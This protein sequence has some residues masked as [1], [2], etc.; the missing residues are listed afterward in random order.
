[1]GLSIFLI[2][3]YTAKWILFVSVKRI[4]SNSAVTELIIQK[5]FEYILFSI[6]TLSSHWVKKIIIKE[7]FPKVLNK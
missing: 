5:L 6:I 1:M 2:K 7:N 4:S 3:K